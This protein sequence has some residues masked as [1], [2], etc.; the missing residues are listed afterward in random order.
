MTP[1]LMGAAIPINA[2]RFA[3]GGFAAFATTIAAATAAAIAAATAATIAAATDAAI[4]AAT[5]ARCIY[6]ALKLCWESSVC[7]TA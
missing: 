1:P 5:A 6:P 4:A 3:S 7:I 2:G